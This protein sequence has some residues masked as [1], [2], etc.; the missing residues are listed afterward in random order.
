MMQKGA[1]YDAGRILTP[2]PHAGRVYFRNECEYND[3][4]IYKHEVTMYIDPNTG[5][6]LFQALAAAFAVVSV[7]LLSF[8]GRIRQF[9]ARMRRKLRKD[10]GEDQE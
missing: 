7:V 4:H 3:F 1:M 10:Q 5:G 9:V 6:V 8:S 2:M